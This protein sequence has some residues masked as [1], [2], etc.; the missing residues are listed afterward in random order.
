MR[1]F[2]K[3][4][5]SKKRIIEEWVYDLVAD[6]LEIGEIR[7]GLW[8]KA[9]ALSEGNMDKCESIYIQLRATS[10]VDEA[11]VAHEVKVAYEAANPT[12]TTQVNKEHLQFNVGDSVFY[13]GHQ[14]LGIGVILENEGKT[15]LVNFPHAVPTRVHKDSLRLKK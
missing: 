11:K 15:A 12:P 6:E 14:D 10:I 9:K 1:F 8:T 5:S 3:N 13:I 2:T 4:R 7:K